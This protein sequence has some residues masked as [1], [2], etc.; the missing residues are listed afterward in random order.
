MQLSATRLAPTEHKYW[1]RLAESYRGIG[2]RIEEQLAYEKAILFGIEAEKVNPND[3]ETL[4]LLSL[5][6]THTGATEDAR[7][8]GKFQALVE[9]PTNSA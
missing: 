3:W 4:G 6:Q 5:Y 1:G 7:E 9:K 8:L 2:N